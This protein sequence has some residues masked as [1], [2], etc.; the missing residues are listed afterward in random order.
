MYM[1]VYLPMAQPREGNNG[2]EILESKLMD[3]SPQEVLD[4]ME[5]T[6]V[7]LSLPKFYVESKIE[8]SH[9][10]KKVCKKFKTKTLLEGHKVITRTSCNYVTPVFFVNLDGD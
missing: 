8:V 6:L 1:I 4:E 3:L 10:L 5:T 9:C 7:K 2:L